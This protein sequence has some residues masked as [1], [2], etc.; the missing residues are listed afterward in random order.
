MCQTSILVYSRLQDD[1]LG[2]FLSE[3]QT[4]DGVTLQIEWVYADAHRVALFYSLD[5]TES[6]YAPVNIAAVDVQLRTAD[7]T[8][9][10]HI[11]GGGGGGSGGGVVAVAVKIAGSPHPPIPVGLFRAA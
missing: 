2:V 9:L 6:P 10:P 5:Q 1:E 11:F 4:V 7:G 3:S 8:V